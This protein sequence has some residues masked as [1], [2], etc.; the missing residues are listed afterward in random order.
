MRQEDPEVFAATHE[1]PLRLV[2]EGVRRAPDRPSRRDRGPG[3]YFQRLRD[4]GAL[5]VWIEKVLEPS[6]RL[7]DWPVLGTVGYEFLN[8]VCALFVDGAAEQAFTNLW[9]RVS[10]DQRDFDAVAFD[11]K[12]EQAHDV[13]PRD[14]TART[15]SRR[16]TGE[17]RRSRRCRSTGPTSIRRRAR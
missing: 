1:L 6:E 3:R 11:A 7:R 9:V 17:S 16:L 5:R 14:R 10:G 13:C 12:L 15:G 4:G 2:R 8:D